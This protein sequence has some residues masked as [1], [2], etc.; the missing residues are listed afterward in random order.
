MDRP[1][2]KTAILLFL[3]ALAIRLSFYFIAS[4]NL[5][6][7]MQKFVTADTVFY[8]DPLALKMAAGSSAETSLLSATRFTFLGY[9]ALFYRY[10]GYHYWPVSIFH[11]FLSALSVVLLFLTTRL[12]F[13]ER[14]AFI[15]GLVAAFQ[16]V[17]VYWTPFVTTEAV[18]LL[19]MSLSI[20]LFGLFLKERKPCY[21]ILL[22]IFLILM[23]VSR[24]LGITFSIFMLA[25]LEWI[26]LKRIF[27]KNNTA[28]FLIVN[29][30]VLAAIIMLLPKFSLKIN[31]VLAQEYP[32]ELLQ[33]SLYIDQ[34]P[35]L[36]SGKGHLKF[37]SARITL[38]PGLRIPRA[39][40]VP[41]QIRLEEIYS[42]FGRNLPKFISLVVS[43]IYTLFNPW[44]P[45]Y[46]LRHNIFNLLFYG[47]IYIFSIIG[48]FFIW[49]KNRAFAILIL[50]C[51]ASQ[52]FLISLT[53]V[54]YDFRFRLSI[55]FILTIPVG[56][57]VSR[58]LKM[59]G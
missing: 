49:I 22:L 2:I 14:T 18:F 59:E 36:E 30:V 27:S 45:E 29:T 9:L 1:K 5:P 17:L 43:R 4:N 39:D 13:K 35:K 37:Y 33:M 32:Q 28:L 24:P 23:P 40:S 6:E 46:S 8:Y 57:A 54:D 26:G 44:V 53:L 20:Y 21:L 16:I 10:L 52:I 7:N 19:I 15:A 55:E 31:K 48:L 11:C 34:M 3:I 50:A 56:V 12:F 51:L 25:C 38:P 41:A 47:F 58:T 42:Y